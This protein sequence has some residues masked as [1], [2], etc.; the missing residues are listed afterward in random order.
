[1][2][3]AKVVGCQTVVGGCCVNERSIR[4]ADQGIEAGV[5]HHNDKN[6]LKIFEVGTTVLR[7]NRRRSD[8]GKTKKQQ[9]WKNGNS[10]Q[11]KTG[12]C[13]SGAS[14][15]SDFCFGRGVYTRRPKL[16]EQLGLRKDFQTRTLM[17]DYSGHRVGLTLR[18]KRA[19][20]CLV[21]ETQNSWHRLPHFC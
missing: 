19:G 17:L 9:N 4:V 15:E 6:V 18:I 3:H 2:G 8:E 20:G 16:G 7:A 5:L 10:R 11:R 21:E 14:C 1:M 12:L 13:S